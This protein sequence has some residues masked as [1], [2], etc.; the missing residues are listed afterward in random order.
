[1]PIEDATRRFTP[2][3]ENYA[4][5]RPG[6]PREVLDLL[7]RECR[8]TPDSLVAD[9]GFGTGLFTRLLLEN[10]NRVIGVEPNPD[11]R[12]AG[13]RFLASYPRFTSLSGTAEAPT[14]PGQSVHI[15]AVAQAAHWFDARRARTEFERILKPGG[16]TVLVWND[17]RMDATGFQRQYEQL[18][19]TYGADYEAVRQRGM[20]LAIEAFFAP[21][22]FET[23]EFEN[24]QTFDY[25]GLEGR[26]L[27]SA[28]VPQK[29]EEKH[30]PMLL[31]LRRIFDEYQIDGRILI[32]Y[33]TRVHYGQLK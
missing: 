11:M 22:N 32:D 31:D 1:M 9:V 15:V 29:G 12:R 24:H 8:L 5:Y 19:R 21:S 2:R 7:R 6:Y 10:G 16:W 4:R 18:L 25:S 14:L 20:T 26:L 30:E 17:R 28:Y 3:V 33:D 23:R 27:S 13:E